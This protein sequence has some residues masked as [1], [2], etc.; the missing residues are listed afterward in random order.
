MNLDLIKVA[1]DLRT[2]HTQG[3]AFRLPAMTVR[4]LE[5]LSRLLDD[6]RPVAASALIH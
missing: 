4:D 2:F 6:A 3:V 5:I 1:Q